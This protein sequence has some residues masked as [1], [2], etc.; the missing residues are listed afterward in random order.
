MAKIK[1]KQAENRTFRPVMWT[2]WA[3]ASRGGEG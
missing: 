3:E 2:L 1:A